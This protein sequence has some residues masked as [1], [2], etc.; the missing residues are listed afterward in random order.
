MRVSRTA[1]LAAL[2][3][4]AGC[5]GSAEPATTAAGCRILDRLARLPAELVETSG[6]AA[7]RAHAGVLWTHNDSDDAGAYAIQANG[8]LLGRTEISGA[9]NLDWEDVAVGPCEGGDCLYLADTGDNERRRDDRGLYR[10]REPAPGAPESAPAEHFPIRYPDGRYDTEAV[11]VMPSGEVYFVSKGRVDAQI[12][13]R[14]PMPLR[15]GE[16]VELQPVATLGPG[17]ED[18][19]LQITGASASPSGRWIAIREYKR[20]TVHRASDLVAGR[21]APVLQ[22]DLTPVGEEQG[23]GV[24]ILDNGRVVLTSEGAL[25]GSSGTISLLQCELPAE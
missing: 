13:F 5:T 3:L 11:F 15:A 2:A 10:V 23:E 14:Y 25:Q 18:F 1:P 22:V 8:A 7:S 12:I 19:L 9:K 24:A 6:V 17:R 20:L 4:L 21:V 16:R